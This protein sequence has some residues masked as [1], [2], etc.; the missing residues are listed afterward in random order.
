MELKDLL[1]EIPG[2]NKRLVY[3]LESQGFIQPTQVRKLRINRRDYGIEDLQRVKQFWTYYARGH[4]VRSAMESAARAEQSVVIAL[5]PV[6]YRNRQRTLEVLR[7]FA[8]V[9]EA[10]VVYGETGDLIVWMKAADEHDVYGVLDRVFET[11]SV[12][13]VPRLWRVVDDCEQVRS[14]PHAAELSP[15]KEKQVLAY[16][17]IKAPPKQVGDVVEKLRKFSGIVEACA[18]YGES[19]VIA[20]IIVARQDDLDNLVMNQIQSLPAVEST[21]TFI[22]VGG[23]HWE[24]AAAEVG[25]S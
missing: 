16:V 13:G 14:S 12:I 2:L 22:A 15:E 19:D 4:S 23:M 25:G 5:L 8:R 20:K 1:S 21:R 3:Y 11:A 7:E 17:L 9:R 6:A 24:R 10:A 18:L